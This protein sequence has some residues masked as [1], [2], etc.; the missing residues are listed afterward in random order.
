MSPMSAHADA[1]K[2]KIVRLF[3]TGCTRAEDIAFAWLP[4]SRSLGDAARP[5]KTQPIMVQWSEQQLGT[6]STQTLLG[7]LLCFR[8]KLK[9]PW[10]AASGQ[11][12]PK[13]ASRKRSSG[14]RCSCCRSAIAASAESSTRNDK[15]ALQAAGWSCLRLSHVLPLL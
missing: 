6:G 1:V 15:S 9:D 7:R 4:F 12:G 13:R 14:S 3:S 2:K 8:I 10:I 11:L 5:P